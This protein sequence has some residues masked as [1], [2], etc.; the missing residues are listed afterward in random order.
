MSPL[1]LPFPYDIQPPDPSDSIVEDKSAYI[2]KWLAS[3]E[4]V[5]PAP[6]TPET[7]LCKYY[8]ENRDQPRELIGLSETGLR[9]CVPHLHVGDAFAMLGTPTLA[10][11][12]DEEGDPAPSH[13]ETEVS[14]RQELVDV[15]SGHAVLMSPNTPDG[16]SSET[17][18]APWSLRYSGHQ[19]GSW[20]GQLGDGRAISIR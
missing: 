1:P 11:A 12:F 8:P 6:G 14:A 16:T 18:F 19:F 3:R 10:N 20:A 13:L 9:D 15:L 2:E 17:A 5:H 7:P 4:A